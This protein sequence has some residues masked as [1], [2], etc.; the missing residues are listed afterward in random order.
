MAATAPVPTQPESQFTLALFDL[1]EGARASHL[2]GRLGWQDIRRHYRRS[3]LGPFWITISMGVLVA[4]LGTLYGGLFQVDMA[5]YV[6]YLTLGWVVWTLVSGLIT[7]GCAAFVSASSIIQQ[8]RLPLSVHV[9]RGIWR[10]LITFFH[11]AVIFVAV[12]VLFAIWPGWVGLLAIPGLLLVCLNGV[13]VGIV[14]GIFAT[15][16]RDVPPIIASVVR[17]AFFVTPIIW[18]P[19]LLPE[20]ALVPLAFNPFY[21]V[22]EVVRAPLLGEVPSAT[23]WLAMIGFTLVSALVMLGMY[24][25]FRW[26]IA[27]WL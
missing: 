26:R 3:I 24:V 8:A 18:M 11:N 7:D 9:Y 25:R 13:C 1:V 23:S 15:R 19:E 14:L 6:P 5:V 2:W 27:Y 16:F 22:L 12:A 10:N 17:I 21:H 20:R 4:V